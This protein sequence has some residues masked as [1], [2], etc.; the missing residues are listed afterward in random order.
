VGRTQ[1]AG[2]DWRNRFGDRRTDRKNIKV[3]R[4]TIAGP[5]GISHAAESSTP[6]TDEVI[7]MMTE[8]QV[9]VERLLVSW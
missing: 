5:E 2:S 6:P 1:L 9:N 3:E 7:P 8:Y 4:S